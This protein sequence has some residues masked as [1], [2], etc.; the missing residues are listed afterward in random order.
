MRVVLCL[1]T[2]GECDFCKNRIRELARIDCEDVTA[3]VW[4]IRSTR[5]LRG[6]IK[7]FSDVDLLYLGADSTIPGIEIAA[8][9][10]K[11]GYK[12]DIVFFTKSKDRVFEAFDVDALHYL[13][14][15]TVEADKFDEVFRKAALRAEA[16]NQASIVL[17]CAGEQRRIPIS[18]IRYFEVINRIVTVHYNGGTFDFYSTLSKIEDVLAKRGFVRIHRSYLVSRKLILGISHGNAVLTDGTRLPVGGRY[19]SNIDLF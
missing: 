10:R 16:R 6:R 2:M 15:G 18:Q 12:G 14:Y 17:S 5:E 8:E 9:L 19:A 13:V 1:S 11:A 7:E 4:E 3:E